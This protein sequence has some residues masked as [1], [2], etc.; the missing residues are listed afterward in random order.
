MKIGIDTFGCDHGQ[1]GIG[2]YLSS[3]LNPLTSNFPDMQWTLFGHETDRYT[4][5][6]N[7]DVTFLGQSIKDSVHAEKNWHVFKCPSFV[8]KNSFD[9]VLYSAGARMLPHKF[10]VPGIAVVNDIV[11]KLY[12]SQNDP[13]L[14]SLMKKGL[15]RVNCIIAPS[16][17]VKKDLEKNGFN[18]RRIE[19]I[20][21]GINHELFHPEDD[22]QSMENENSDMVDIKPFAI[23]KPYFI[24]ASS[25]TSAEKKHIELIKAFS[26]FKKRTGLPHRLVLAGA[27][28]PYS[29]EVHTQA[30]NS[31]AASDIFITG[32]FPHESF[33]ELYRNAEACVFPSV[34]EGIGLPVLEAMATGLPVLC[35][36]QGALG[37]LAGNNALFFDS[38]NIEDI[39][40]ALEKIVADTE[41]RKKLSQDGISWTKRFSWEKT[42]EMT[43][44]VIVQVV[45]GN[46]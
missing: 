25:L 42:A 29:N 34:N 10:N 18:P 44:N 30:F 5:K 21:N 15:A 8:K 4:W 43:K 12:T 27:D 13:S 35:S 23:K 9:A 1:S 26:L 24:Y 19:V 36:K 7:D 17:Y 28:G 32:Y 38:D 11:S 45:E 22:F 46:L 39:A 3:V 37:E 2:S 33:P 40:Q 6:Y 16:Q 31:S 14:K 20:H 41:L